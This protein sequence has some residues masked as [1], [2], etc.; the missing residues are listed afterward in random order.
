MKIL[1]HR[2]NKLLLSIKS[3]FSTQFI[4]DIHL[5]NKSKNRKIFD[6][7]LLYYNSRDG[8]P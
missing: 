1:I 8:P 6:A 5:C 7:R 3:S 2:I 4:V